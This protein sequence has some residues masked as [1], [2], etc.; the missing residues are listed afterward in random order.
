M[1]GLDHEKFKTYGIGDNKEEEGR[2]KNR[3]VLN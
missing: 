1:G 3:R 2:A